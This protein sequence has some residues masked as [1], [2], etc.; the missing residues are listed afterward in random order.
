MTRADVLLTAG[1][2]AS[3]AWL[4]YAWVSLITLVM[5]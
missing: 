2:L 1:L 3:V 5:K 4:A